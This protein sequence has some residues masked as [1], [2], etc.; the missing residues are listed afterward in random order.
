VNKKDAEK[1]FKEFYPHIL[2]ST[3]KPKKA[4]YWNEYTDS[5]CRDGKITEKQRCNW[6]YPKYLKL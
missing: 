4:L 6:M 2:K 3:D 1:Q 5:L